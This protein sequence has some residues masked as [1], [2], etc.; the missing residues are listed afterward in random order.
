[1]LR[2][3]AVAVLAIALMPSDS[4]AQWPVARGDALMTGKATAKLPDTL[5][6]RWEF[7]AGTVKT[8]GVEGAPAIVDG[9]VYLASLDKHLYA[10]GTR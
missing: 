3:L 9:V 2:F 8:G 6:I 4:S 10:V 7:Q 5:E 1:M